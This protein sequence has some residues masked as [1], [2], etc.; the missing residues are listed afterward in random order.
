VA[1][2]T[3]Y[4]FNEPLQQAAEHGLP[5][6]LL[7]GTALGV[8]FLAGVS[9]KKYTP[10]EQDDK[11]RENAYLLLISRAVLLA[12]VVFSLFSYPA[13]IL[14]V[15]TG[16]VLALAYLGGSAKKT[17]FAR[18]LRWKKVFQ[19]KTDKKDTRNPYCSAVGLNA[20]FAVFLPRPQGEKTAKSA[21]LQKI[22]HSGNKV[23]FPLLLILPVICFIF[24]GFN[25]LNAQTEAYKQWKYAYSLYGMG[26]Y[27]QSVAEYETVHPILSRNGDFL[28]NYGKALSMAGQHENAI[29]ILKQA[30][31]WFPNT[32]VY[33]ALGDSY[34]AIGQTQKAEAAYLRAWYMNPS[35]FY[36]KYLLAKLYDENGKREKA[37]AVASELL[38]KKVKVQSTAVDEIK[39]E[40][41][42]ILNKNAS[43]R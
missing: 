5:G 12:I 2:D 6:M 40:M 24:Y 26:A 37:V 28:T 36:P 33:T 31:R 8:A 42:N 13:Q 16:L 3:N 10:G 43:G 21:S 1:G 27:E 22:Q 35:R 23:F 11:N 25:F 18:F 29:Q 20:D 34:K 17:E 9:L 19:V 38:A 7:L 41:L 14:P 4:A 30:T 15:K 32:V 39:A